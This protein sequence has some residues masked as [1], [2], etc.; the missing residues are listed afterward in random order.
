VLARGHVRPC[1][2]D[3]LPGVVD[4]Y[5][6]VFPIGRHYS[7]SRL[8]ARFRR[9]LF[10]NPWCDDTIPSLLYEKDGKLLGF[11]GVVVRRML[12]GTEI[13]R[14]AVSN[15]FMVEPS[16]RATG[17]GIELLHRHFS[18]KQ[19]L[20]VAESGDASRRIW[21]GVGGQT[22]FGYSL[23]WI[24][25]LRPARYC[26]YQLE[27]KRISRT[28][29]WMFGPLCTGVDALA[30]R[31]PQ[32]PFYQ[33]AQAEEE[34]LS[35]SDLVHC[36]AGFPKP[37]ALRPY[38]DENSLRWLLA[39]LAEKRLL[40]IL[41]KVG[42]RDQQGA[43]SGWYI[44]YLD[45]QGVST[46]LQLNAIPGCFDHVFQHLC[47]HAWRHGSIAVTGRL[48]P[49]FTKDLCGNQCM[50]RWRSWML[51]HSRSPRIIEA[52]HTKETFF[53]SLEGESWISV[54]GEPA[55]KPSTGPC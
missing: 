6:K 33:T 39:V 35:E 24:R 15:H 17:A 1:V 41:R 28:L 44:Y 19:D 21:E 31:I 51:V 5:Q 34:E 42:M 26:L 16:A 47:H 32:G 54:D 36:L 11:L 53:S 9:V 49:R 18:G 46:V 14:V 7:W 43:I 30:V 13:V 4:L 52:L 55:D 2:V 48:E 38:Y 20:S 27:K 37:T 50:L 12:L 40:G 29:A 8:H 10:Q 3:D 25:I 23:H 45:R 22:S